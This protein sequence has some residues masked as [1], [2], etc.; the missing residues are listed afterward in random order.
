MSKTH[1]TVQG[2]MWDGI[3]YDELGDTQYTDALMRANRQYLH[4]FTFPAGIVLQL[5]EVTQ[6]VTSTLP[7]W[8]R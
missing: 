2:E 8:K 1:T 7:P 4:Y 5:P 6:S 3:A